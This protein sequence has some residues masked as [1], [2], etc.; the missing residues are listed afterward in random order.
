MRNRLV[1]GNL[2]D[3]V[4]RDAL[5][6]VTFILH[7]GMRSSR[8]R[9]GRRGR[10]SSL[11]ATGRPMAVATARMLVIISS[12]ISM[13]R[14]CT[15]SHHAVSGRGCTSTMRPSAPAATAASASAGTNA[16]CPPRG[17]GRR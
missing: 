4:E 2:E 15:P 8:T 1:A 12:N 13:E 3:A 7:R 9:R 10:S 17:S 16:V 5:S 6:M 14:L 11:R